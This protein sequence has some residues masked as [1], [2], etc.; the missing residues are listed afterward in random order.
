MLASIELEVD[1]FRDVLHSVLLSSAILARFLSWNS[2][3]PTAGAA[4]RNLFGTALSAPSQLTSQSL[5]ELGARGPVLPV[6][7]RPVGG[8]VAGEGEGAT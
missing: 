8:A 7:V 6:S 4:A 3:L 1:L 2:P 5:G